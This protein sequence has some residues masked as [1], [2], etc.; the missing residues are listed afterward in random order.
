MKERS[1]STLFLMEQLIVIAVFALCA[2][3]CVRILASSYLMA[4]ESR[5][6]LNAIRAAES[7][8]E[9]FKAVSGDAVKLAEI[10]GGTYE[11]I[12]GSAM[13]V[14]YYNN[15]WDVCDMTDQNVRYIL[16]LVIDDSAEQLST[17]SSG[18]LIIEKSTGE[19]IIAIP[20]A[21]RG[22]VAV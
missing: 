2:A 4:V 18:E 3:A 1:K 6:K 14:V 11:N 8:A 5:D 10:I 17:L 7:G 15:E 19:R 21:A 20:V 12:D 13:V 9:C 16:R 22:G